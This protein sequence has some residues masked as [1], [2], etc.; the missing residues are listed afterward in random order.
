MYSTFTTMKF[1]PGSNF[2]MNLYLDRSVGLKKN[3]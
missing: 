1:G 2:H 3:N